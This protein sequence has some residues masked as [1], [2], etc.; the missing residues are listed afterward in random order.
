MRRSSP[1]VQSDPDTDSTTRPPAPAKP[2]RDASTTRPKLPLAAAVWDSMSFARRC[3]L[4]RVGDGVLKQFYLALALLGQPLKRADFAVFRMR[5]ENLLF[6]LEVSKNTF[7][8]RRK[9]LEALGLLDIKRT[10]KSTYV[11][12]FARF[13][14]ASPPPFAKDTDWHEAAVPEQPGFPTPLGNQISHPP[15]NSIDLDL[16]VQDHPPAAAKY[17]RRG[18]RGASD[19]PGN[20]QQQHEKLR[21]PTTTTPGA[22]PPANGRTV[23]GDGEKG[24]GETTGERTRKRFKGLVAT[25]A[26]RTRVAGGSFNDEDER[27]IVDSFTAGK[28]TLRDLQRRADELKAAIAAAPAAAT[29]PSPA[30]RP[31]RR[32]RRGERPDLT[33][34]EYV[35]WEASGRNPEAPRRYREEQRLALENEGEQGQ[36][37]E[38]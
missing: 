30:P 34:A 37:G 36:A 35:V 24:M 10:A 33:D 9:Q 11:R 6:I 25:I 5:L 15:G 21:P 2:L 38:P 29:K 14:A 32:R 22:R 26:A 17:G 27:R 20:Q 3:A 31:V 8:R 7:Y 19:R 28:L 13:V 4:V 16:R 12:V 1:E 18:D 23:A